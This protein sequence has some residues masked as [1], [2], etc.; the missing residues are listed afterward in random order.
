MTILDPNE[1]IVFKSAHKDFRHGRVSV[2]FVNDSIPRY[3]DSDT[4]FTIQSLLDAEIVQ[5]E[6]EANKENISITID[7]LAL[8]KINDLKSLYP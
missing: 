8:N 2:I 6:H 3:V 4:L 1:W 7:D 5:S